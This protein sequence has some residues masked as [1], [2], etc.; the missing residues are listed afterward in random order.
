MAAANT[1]VLNKLYIIIRAIKYLFKLRYPKTSDTELYQLAKEILDFDKYYY[2]FDRIED[3]RLKLK[4]TKKSIP[5]TEMGAGSKI[6]TSRNR[7]IA[8]IARRGTSAPWHCQALFRLA[9]HFQPQTLLEIGTSVGISTAYLASACPNSKVFTLEGDPAIASV[10]KEG[11]TRLKIDNISLI[12]GE[13][14]NSLDQILN[15]IS[16]V[17]LAFIDGNHK[18]EPTYRYFTRILEH[19]N[20]QSVLVFDDIHWS[21]E[22]ESC[23]QKIKNHG[24]VHGSLD[25]YQFGI[26]FLNS[27]YSGHF[28]IIPR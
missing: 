17:G 10:A 28:I 6:S 22:M 19:C 16:P 7:L 14:D 8:D 3:W 5:I 4:T 21:N 11:F 23:W 25:C 12:P 27:S 15:S 24:A 26:L 1:S 2:S 9:R 18:K 13:F 20:E